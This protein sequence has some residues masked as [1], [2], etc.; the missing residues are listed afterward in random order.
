MNKNDFCRR[1]NLTN[2]ASV[3]NWFVDRLVDYLGFEEE[4]TLLKTSIRE[5]KVGQG[6]RSFLYKPDYV[7]LVNGFPTVVIDAKH[8]DECIDDWTSQCSSYC[9][10]LNKLY[11]YNPV[12]YFLLTNGLL[13]KVYKWDLAKPSIEIRFEEFIE[14]NVL[15]KEL[16]TTISKQALNLL[17]EPNVKT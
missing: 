6:S 11:E 10:E 17:T 14:G 2:E 7:L 1:S 16:K 3:E 12:E 5:F 4:D 13:T 9:L 8:P 15:L